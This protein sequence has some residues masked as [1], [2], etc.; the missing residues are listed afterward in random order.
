[1]AA[2]PE[3]VGLA[4][5]NFA[6]EYEPLFKRARSQYFCTIREPTAIEPFHS[7]ERA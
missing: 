5:S 3:L 4:L 2:A 6:M 7:K 1:M